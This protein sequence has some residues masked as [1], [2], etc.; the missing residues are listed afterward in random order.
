[1]NWNF[2]VV[3]TNFEFVY[4][5]NYAIVVILNGLGLLI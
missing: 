2:E 1:M 3:C 5:T 4:V